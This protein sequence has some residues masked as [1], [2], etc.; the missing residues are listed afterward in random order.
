MTTH[1]LI[2]EA[3]EK[4]VQALT[5]ALGRIKELESELF[6]A[7]QAILREGIR[8]GDL[9][10]SVSEFRGLAQAHRDQ[11]EYYREECKRLQN[12]VND[13]GFGTVYQCDGPSE[14]LDDAVPYITGESRASVR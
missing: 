1:P 9:E 8:A 13:D 4:A 7:R 10:R 3:L 11:V 6:E 5:F 2:H 14:H 12:E